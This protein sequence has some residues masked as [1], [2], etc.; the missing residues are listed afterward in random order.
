MLCI[1][2]IWVISGLNLIVKHSIAVVKLIMC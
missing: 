1:Q 2:L